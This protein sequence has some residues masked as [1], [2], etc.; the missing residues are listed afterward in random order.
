MES[1]TS[2]L[3][4]L[5]RQDQL[6]DHECDRR[7]T[8]P[9]DIGEYQRRALRTRIDM[10][11]RRETSNNM[12]RFSWL[13]SDLIVLRWPLDFGTS[14]DKALN[15][16]LRSDAHVDKG[17]CEV[18]AYRGLISRLDQ[19]LFLGFGVGGNVITCG[20]KDLRWLHGVIEGLLVG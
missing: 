15:V 12:I 18:V 20:H 6:L 3:I 17:S 8:G 14:A 19:V 5:C 9:C 16:L 10:P 13:G 2:S 1:V 4:A 11:F 7:C